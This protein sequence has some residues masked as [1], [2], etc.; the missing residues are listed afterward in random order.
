M[1][2]VDSAS[3]TLRLPLNFA[4]NGPDGGGDRHFILVWGS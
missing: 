1:I 3:V 4:F 2:A